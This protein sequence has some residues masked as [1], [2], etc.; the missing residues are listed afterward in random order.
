MTPFRSNEPH[1]G[2]VQ[3]A[4]MAERF[5]YRVSRAR[6]CPR[7][8]AGKQCVRLNGPNR[9][10]P[11][12]KWWG[13][14]LDHGRIWLDRDGRHVLTGEPYHI[15]TDELADFRREMAE[16]GLEVTTED[17]SAWNPGSCTLVT[18][19]RP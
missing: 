9:D 3:T 11:C 18:V 8:V 2:V 4:R 6:L 19:T 14:I 12:Q 10:C 7:V 1:P 16:L 13:S 15:A 5:G 17:W